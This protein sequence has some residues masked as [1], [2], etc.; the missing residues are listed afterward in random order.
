MTSATSS[1]ASNDME[2][3]MP[4]RQ[5]LP[6]ALYAGPGFIAAPEPS[7]L[8]MPSSLMARAA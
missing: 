7:M 2:L 6:R 1:S 3:D 5:L 4:R 8:P